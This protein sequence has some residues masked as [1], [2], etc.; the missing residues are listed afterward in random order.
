MSELQL[1]TFVSSPILR[2]TENF[3]ILQDEEWQ[4]S[5]SPNLHD[6]HCILRLVA[7]RDW[8]KFLRSW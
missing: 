2:E 1:K 5:V 7:F 8:I 6:L 4:F 3:H